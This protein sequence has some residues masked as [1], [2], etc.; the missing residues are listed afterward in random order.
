M[1][2]ISIFYKI[3]TFLG[4]KIEIYLVDSA[5]MYIV[6]GINLLY[7]NFTLHDVTPPSQSAL[8]SVARNWV[9][10]SSVTPLIT[11]G[12]DVNVLKLQR[13]VRCNSV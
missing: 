12:A 8:I 1:P 11:N 9:V 10:I 6:V 13:Y 5:S 4:K 2:K 3:R 7:N